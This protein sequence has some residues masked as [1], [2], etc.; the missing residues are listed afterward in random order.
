MSRETRLAFPDFSKEFY[1]Y[2]DASDYQ[3]GVLIIQNDKPLAFYSREL[4]LAQK[5]IQ[6]ENK[7]SFL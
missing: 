3:L 7:N 6:Q 2:T 1:I 4:N 5:T